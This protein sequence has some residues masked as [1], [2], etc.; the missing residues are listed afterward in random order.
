MNVR[1]KHGASYL[2]TFI[3]DF[4]KF[5]YVYLIS[6][7]SEALW[8]FRKFLNLV[9]NQKDVRLKALRTDRGREYL[10]DQFKQI[11]DEKGNERKLTILGIPQ[12]NDVAKRRNR[13]F[14]EMVR[15]IMKQ[16]N[17]SIFYWGD[18]LLIAT[19]VLNRVPLSLLLLH[20]MN[21]GLDVSLI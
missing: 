1:A 6:H 9:E 13:T 12:Q 15:S 8:C 4:T 18:A 11:F 21:Y 20:H 19:Y 16:I 3:D 2:I 10:S 5:D 17:L 7:K 14:L